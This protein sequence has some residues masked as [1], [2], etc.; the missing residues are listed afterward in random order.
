MNSRIKELA[1]QA[2]ATKKYV[3][4]VWQFFDS[5]LEQFVKL[6]IDESITVMTQHDYH[7]EWLGEKLKQHFSFN[8]E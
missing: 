1:E 4:P 8:D 3:P 2:A 7:G 6:L 5:E